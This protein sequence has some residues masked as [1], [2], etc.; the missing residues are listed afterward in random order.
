MPQPAPVTRIIYRARQFFT[1]LGAQVAP[2]E[3]EAALKQS[4]MPSA[5]GSLFRQL[6]TPYQRHALNVFHRL[7]NQQSADTALLQAAL[8][9]DSGKWDPKTGQRVNIIVRVAVTLLQ[10]SGPGRKL[11]DKLGSRQKPVRRWRCSFILQ[12]HHPELGAELARQR[13]ANPDTVLLIR[14]HDQPLATAPEYLRE[15][16]ALLQQAD[17]ME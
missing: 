14:L 9:H 13:A 4:A 17:D 16:L 12:Q 6:P 5:A 3:L 7:V 15:R 2:A 10:L 8:L 11:L 1:A